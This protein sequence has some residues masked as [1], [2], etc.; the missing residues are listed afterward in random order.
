MSRSFLF[1]LTVQL[2]WILPGTSARE[3]Y[4]L[5]LDASQRK[6]NEE[7]DRAWLIESYVK[8]YEKQGVKNASWD[9]DVKKVSDG[10]VEYML[11]NQM[12]PYLPRATQDAAA[13]ARKSGCQDIL[14][15]YAALRSMDQANLANPQGLLN[16]FLQVGKDVPK[17]YYPSAVKLEMEVFLGVTPA[18]NSA[19]WKEAEKAEIRKILMQALDLLVESSLKDAP[20]PLMEYRWHYACSE[21]INGFKNLGDRSEKAW[22]TVDAALAKCN[23]FETKRIRTKGSWMVQYAWEARGYGTIDKTTEEGLKKFTERLNQAKELLETAWKLEP[24]PIIAEARMRVE[25]GIGKGDRKSIET[26]FRRSIGNRNYDRNSIGIMREWLS[27]KWYGD[28]GSL[29]EFLEACRDCGNNRDVISVQYLD[30]KYVEALR[31]PKEAKLEHFKDPKFFQE[32]SKV[33]AAY[34]AVNPDDNYY[35]GRYAVFSYY[36][37][38]YAEALKQFELIGEDMVESKHA[39][40]NRQIF[41]KEDLLKNRVPK[42]K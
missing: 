24:S 13:R 11:S 38:Q 31:L 9:G 3:K 34:L 35:R 19:A 20:T 12:T 8:P 30:E 17:S 39:E 4:V 26:W 29:W 32:M 2:I 33:F 41:L 18:Q 25:L 6:K 28:E 16:L 37:G 23:K 40:I 22:E 1:G 10:F 14:V 42:S 21:L 27:P 7:A 5:P 36:C 15:R